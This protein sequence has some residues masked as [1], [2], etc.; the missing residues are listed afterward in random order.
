MSKKRIS[1]RVKLILSVLVSLA[2]AVGLFFV[3]YWIGNV[4]ID[5]Y[6]ATESYAEKWRQDWFS[7]LQEFADEQQITL[8][9]T[10]VLLEYMESQPLVY[11][12]ADVSRGDD[13]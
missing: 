1:L 6:V 4:Y 3:L 13:V 8:T 10:S 7:D 5:R 11:V 9:D 12:V 2:A